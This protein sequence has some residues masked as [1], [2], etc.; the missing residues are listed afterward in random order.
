MIII[1]FLI[2][3]NIILISSDY[4]S[5]LDVA[6]YLIEKNYRWLA[7]LFLWNLLERQIVISDEETNILFK[8]NVI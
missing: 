7:V 3:E 1:Y 2:F 8:S 6:K 5:D 4:P